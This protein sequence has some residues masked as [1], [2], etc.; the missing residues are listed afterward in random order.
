VAGVGA[1]A[2]L[3][4]PVVG[5]RTG[6]LGEASRGLPQGLAFL[7]TGAVAVRARP[8]HRGARRLL[9]VALVMCAGDALGS[10]Y[11]A[12]GLTHPPASWG[13]AAV[14]ALQ[15]LD[16]A[17]GALLLALLAVFPDGHYHRDYERTVVIAGIAYAAAVVGAARLGSRELV[18]PGAFVWA[19]QVSAPNPG[20]KP[21]LEP[22]GHFAWV[23]YQGGF[24]VLL[25][26]GVALLG[27]RF[28][29][30]G[31]LERRQTAW[32]LYGVLVA[33]IWGLLLGV[34]SGSTRT[35]PAG[36]L[37]LLYTPAALAVPATIAIGM[38]R[39][40]LL[41]IDIVIRRSAVYA[42]LWL[43]ISAAYLAVALAFGVAVGAR[44][45]L[46]LAI[47]LTVVATL[48]AAPARRR[49]E[50]LADRLVYGRRLSG[51]ELIAQLGARLE[52]APGAEDVAGTVAADVR[53][54][55]GASW[56][57]VVLDDAGQRVVGSAGT[58]ATDAAPALRVPLVRGQQ[59]V[60]AIECGPRDQG[61]Y[62]EVDRQL[63]ETL[64]RQAALAV[65][66]SWLSVQLARR[67]AELTASRAR[68][69]QAEDAGRRRLERD[70]HDGVQQELVAM[71]AR[72]GLARNQLRRDA[73]LAEASLRD[74]A[75]DAQRALVSLQEV[76]RGIHPPLL[77]DQGLVEAVRART[78]RLTLPVEVTTAGLNGSGRFPAEV[79]GA[80]YFVVIEALGNVLKHARASHAWVELAAAPDALRVTVRD[81][82]CGFDTSTAR[83]QGLLGL[84]DRVEAL[85]GTL[86]VTS[87]Q[88]VGT[89]L[90]ASIPRGADDDGEDDGDD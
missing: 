82:G 90:T 79:E 5:W 14:L 17:Q 27:L 86:R 80:A 70:L 28:R 56:V 76:A 62:S 12:Y 85:A 4:A 16:L 38:V 65:H 87:A 8:D 50:S 37:Y 29:H 78:T 1:L 33:V 55:L 42:A 61:R 32:P 51:Y 23:A 67:L 48:V 84:Q 2:L 21:G 73:T 31:P 54:G 63:L 36:V 68:I 69:V 30:F 34:V 7:V 10:A 72:L 83:R 24:L 60:G 52:A 75:R 58:V 22:V 47:A 18:Y 77:T 20:A 88:G 74:V 40:R 46:A 3:S 11:S 35:L 44:V 41:D 89:T 15:G 45:P 6:H 19:D 64:G 25:A 13:W 39:H 66:N 53:A 81:D 43:L 57:S 49:L 71:L 59:T 26:T 9:C